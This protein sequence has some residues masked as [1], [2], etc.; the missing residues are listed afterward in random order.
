MVRRNLF[1]VLFVLT[2]IPLSGCGT[3]VPRIEEFWEPVDVLPSME[4]KIKQNIFCETVRALR[5]VKRDLTINGQPI[6]SDSFG[7]QMQIT[8]TVDEAGALNPSLGLNDVL[9]NAIANKV[10]VPQ[11]FALNGAATASSTVTRTD[12]SYSYYNVGR[13][14]ATGANPFCDQNQPDLNGSSPLLRSDLG[15]EAFLREALPGAMVFHSSPQ[16]KGGAGKTAKLD[17][18][19]YEI[20]FAVV[21]NASINP[22]WKLVN[23]TSGTGSLP[24]VSAGR[25][26]THDLTLTFGPGVNT[27]TEFAL[28]THFTSQIVQ[29]NMRRQRQGT[30]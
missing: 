22:T 20:K 4:T 1:A 19:S 24:L 30:P 23:L 2:A 14:T 29:S 13:I 26:R 11:S 28:Q 3:R 15:I 21:T 27:P 9:P 7:V 17:V 25:T 18:F 6:I 8:L 5:D 12:S 10:T 16:A